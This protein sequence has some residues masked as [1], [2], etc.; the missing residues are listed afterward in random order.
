MIGSMTTAAP[1]LDRMAA[2]ATGWMAKHTGNKMMMLV[3][4]CI[5]QRKTDDERRVP[6][7]DLMMIFAWLAIW[8]LAFNHM[9]DVTN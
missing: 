8:K 5:S 6:T 4:Q 7:C 3:L 2:T 1:R 9:V